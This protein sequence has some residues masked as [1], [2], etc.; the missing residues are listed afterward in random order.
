MGRPPG[1]YKRP[2]GVL[3]VE[4]ITTAAYTFKDGQPQTTQDGLTWH[5]GRYRFRY[6]EDGKVTRWYTA[7]QAPKWLMVMIREVRDAQ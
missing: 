3:E 2:A 5:T 7:G 6:D 1:T 4:G